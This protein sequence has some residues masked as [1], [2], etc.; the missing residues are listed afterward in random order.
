MDNLAKFIKV[1]GNAKMVRTIHSTMCS[2]SD[3]KCYGKLFSIS[4][5]VWQRTKSQG[6]DSDIV[7]NGIHSDAIKA[8]QDKSL[9]SPVRIVCVGRLEEIKGQQV[10]IKAA[11]V[12]RDKGCTDFKIDLIGDGSNHENLARMIN[13]L[14]LNDNVTLLGFKDRTYVYQHLCDYDIY[15]QPSLFEG[16]GLSLA[17]AISAKVPVLTSDLEGPMEVIGEGKYGTSFK[18]GD[19]NDLATKIEAIIKVYD[20]IDTESAYRFVKDYFDIKS[21]YEGYL[22]E[23]QSVLSKS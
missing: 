13:E 12:L 9:H 22:K 14:E 21:T 16:F 15:V 1:K 11:R 18:S 20:K 4:K 17:E 23:Y 19:E 2:G 6:Y 8:R 7:F 3:Y 10:L 5:A